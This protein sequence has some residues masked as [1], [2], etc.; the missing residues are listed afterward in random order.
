MNLSDSSKEIIRQALKVRCAKGMKGKMK[1]AVE[2]EI[3]QTV[4]QVRNHILRIHI[5]VLFATAVLIFACTVF[6]CNK[7]SAKK[8]SELCTA[9][10]TQTEQNVSAFLKKLEDT[11]KLIFSNDKYVSYNA[12]DT[13]NDEYDSIGVE[14]DMTD[15]FVSLSVM[16]NYTDFGMVY[17]NN[18]TVGK[19]TD[20]TRN[21]YSDKIYDAVKE[22][23]DG[24]KTLW[25]TGYNGDYTRIYFARRVNPDAIFLSSFFSTE[26]DSIFFSTANYSDISVMLCADGKIIYS[27]GSESPGSKIDKDI[28]DL[29]AGDSNVTVINANTICAADD[30]ADGWQI[31]TKT[32]MSDKIGSYKRTGVMCFAIT[33]AM[34]II[35][36]L[37]SFAVVAR[38]NPENISA[39]GRLNKLDGATGLYTAEYT[40]N[41]IM[42]KIETCITGSTIALVIVRITNLDLI[43]LNYGEEAVGEA[44]RKVSE[45]I[46]SVFKNED[47]YGLLEEGEFIVFADFTNYDLFKAHDDMKKSLRSLCAMLGEC[48]LDQDRG[49]IRAAV[50]AS[51]YPDC[52]NDYDELLECAEKAA[53]QS[54][55]NDGKYEIYAKEKDHS[56]A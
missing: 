19:I 9:L 49:Y 5:A 39:S 23:L 32:D 36:L 14:N 7:I 2:Y 56:K 4:K 16:G 34:C 26:F 45:I 42:D 3:Y 8:E 37:I 41:A 22:K 31:I 30:C 40:E 52:S 44:Q 54:A 50:G 48:G 20:G 29:I 15:Y 11:S 46:G 55:D 13:S 43:K 18:H 24:E 1:N 10:N 53:A 17:S 27:S 35:H 51:V 47:I 38:K 33:C 12:A 25:L 6:Y 28:S 21:L